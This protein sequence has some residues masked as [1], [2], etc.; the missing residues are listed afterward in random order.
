MEKDFGKEAPFQQ[1]TH[2]D[3]SKEPMQTPDPSLDRVWGSPS[4]LDRI[5]Q[6]LTLL[7]GAPPLEAGSRAAPV[8]S[9]AD[10]P[11]GA[12][13]PGRASNSSSDLPSIMED[14]EGGFIAKLSDGSTVVYRSPYTARPTEKPEFSPDKPIAP[15]SISYTMRFVDEEGEPTP[16]WTPKDGDVVFYCGCIDGVPK[17][18]GVV[19]NHPE[20]EWDKRFITADFGEG[21]GVYLSSDLRPATELEVQQWEAE[22]EAKKP[23]APG[24]VVRHKNSK[25]G[26]YLTSH[27]GTNAHFLALKDGTGDFEIMFCGRGEFKVLEP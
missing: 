13:M 3:L 6:M 10:R 24:V 1:P 12:A 5:E 20:R 15:G 14:G 27:K 7:L 18:A 4:Q 25:E 21:P 19:T 11:S 26:Y 2:F 8:P 17:S 22:Q 16:A 23:L 9:E